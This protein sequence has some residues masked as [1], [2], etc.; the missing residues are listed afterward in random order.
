MLT[1]CAFPALLSLAD[2]PPLQSGVWIR[3]WKPSSNFP[4]FPDPKE[5]AVNFG[6][7]SLAACPQATCCEFSL[8]SLLPLCYQR[9]NADIHEVTCD[10][11][12]MISEKNYFTNNFEAIQTS[13]P[14]NLVWL[15]QF[16]RKLRPFENLHR[17]RNFLTHILPWPWRLRSFLTW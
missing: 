8:S 1:G 12:K 11:E 6:R 2:P 17:F 15:K 10:L 9:A 13:F 7:M 4:G 5:D 3:P 16:L 14:E